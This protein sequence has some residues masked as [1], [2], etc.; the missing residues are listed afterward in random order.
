MRGFDAKFLEEL[1][2]KNDIVDVVG[3]YVQL[4]QRGGNFWGKCPFHHEKTASFSVNTDGNFYYCFGCHKSGDVINFIMEIESL[5]FNDAVK[6]L[7]ERVKMPLPE[8]KYDDE[9]IKEQ[10]KQKDRLL[11]VM[12]ETALYYAHNLRGE[13]GAKHYEYALSRRFTDQTIISFGLGASFDFTSLPNYLRGRGYTDEEMV[14][15]GVC[16]KKDDYVFDW[17]G[18]RLIIPHV[19]QFGNVIAMV[20]RRID[21]GKERKY[22]NTRETPIFSKGKTF[23][24]LNNLKKL[25]NAKGLDSVIL[26]EGHLDVI[27]L[28][29]AGIQNVVASMGTALTKD[30]ARI[31]KRY[32]D[33]VYI[34]YDGDSAG[35]NATLRGLDIL[36]EE[37]LDVKVI[38]IPDGMDPDDVVKKFGVDGYKQL[39]LKAKPL[40]D[41]KLELVKKAHD[42]NSVDGKRRY[43]QKAVSVIRESKSPA[44]QEELLREVSSVSS[45]TFEALK[46]ELYSESVAKKEQVDAVVQF[47]DNVGDKNAIAARFVLSAYLF[48]KPYALETDINSVEFNI[49]AHIE[50]KKFILENQSEQKKIRF[51]DLYEILSEEYHDELARIAGLEVEENKNFDQ[52]V[53]FFDCVRTLKSDKI[54]REIDRLTTLFKS[55]TDNEKRKVYT[56]EM[57]KLIATKNKLN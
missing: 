46:R 6:F 21:G 9:K 23:Y 43:V 57:A 20:G 26:V 32:T 22:V 52:T 4:V 42:L 35:Q 11:A 40:I 39:M 45:I 31:I 5:D 38:D 25:K 13:R 17:L 7:A 41:F 48:N 55:E 54:N 33:K 18:E 15:S 10:R 14:L 47:N 29:Q 16:G 44:E 3:R 27:S 30:Q 56:L 28:S 49:P 1:K 34:S 24:N 36:S 12:R 50:I 53:Y 8:V 19:D 51:S 2:S 37:G